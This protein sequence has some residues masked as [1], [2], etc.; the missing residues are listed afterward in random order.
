MGVWG[1]DIF[2]NDEV[3]DWLHMLIKGDDVTILQTTLNS[4]LINYQQIGMPKACEVLAAAEI[5]R[6]VANGSASDLPDDYRAWIM[7]RDQIRYKELV[8]LA[9]KAV[10]RVIENSEL[11][12][13]W[14]KTTHFEE[15]KVNLDV[16]E[17]QLT[18]IYI[19]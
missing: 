2:E 12:D 10:R 9:R 7:S 6:A 1:Y 19:V 15:W 5:I 4:A 8:A 11:R 14:S 18:R 3:L 13:L 16:L 17:A